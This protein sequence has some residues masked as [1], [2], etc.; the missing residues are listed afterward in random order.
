MSKRAH[1]SN[2]ITP[3]ERVPLEVELFYSPEGETDLVGSTLCR[4][5]NFVILGA[6]LSVGLME[7]SLSLDSWKGSFEGIFRRSVDPL[8]VGLR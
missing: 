2:N 4:G 1:V 7:V 3:L 6:D 8:G 5:F